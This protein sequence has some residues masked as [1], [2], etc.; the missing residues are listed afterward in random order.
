MSIREAILKAAD[1]IER[2]PSDYDYQANHKPRCGSP[3]CLM[4]W[5]G[6]YAGIPINDNHGTYMSTLKH[7]LGFDY[8]DLQVELA[9]QFHGYT[10]VAQT[11]ARLLR[12]YADKH[13]P[14]TRVLPPNWQAMASTRTV[15]ADAVDE[16]VRA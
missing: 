7:V 2:V 15:P 9:D 3:G 5:V 8:I 14:A 4:G 13:Y 16:M 1:H 10:T 12:A 11:G 6:F